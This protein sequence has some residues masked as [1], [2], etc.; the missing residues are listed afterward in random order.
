MPTVPPRAPGAQ[1]FYRLRLERKT[2]RWGGWYVP[3]TWQTDGDGAA[4]S[5]VSG[6]PRACFTTLA[7]ARACL[8]KY[9][10]A[11]PKARIV[12]VNAD[13]VRRQHARA[14][15]RLCIENAGGACAVCG[16]W[17]SSCEQC[18]GRGYHEATCPT[19]QGEGPGPYTFHYRGGP[20]VAFVGP[21][22]T[23]DEPAEADARHTLDEEARKQLEAYYTTSGFGDRRPPGPLEEERWTL[24]ELAANVCAAMDNLLADRAELYELRARLGDFGTKA[25]A[26]PPF[27][28]QGGEAATPE[29]GGASGGGAFLDVRSEE[30]AP[31][32]PAGPPQ[33]ESA[34]GG[35]P[36]AKGPPL[37]SHGRDFNLP[38]PACG[39]PALAEELAEEPLGGADLRD[40]LRRAIDAGRKPEP[41]DGPPPMC[42]TRSRVLTSIADACGRDGFGNAEAEDAAEALVRLAKMG[43]LNIHEATDA[44]RVLLARAALLGAASVKPP[45]SAAMWAAAQQRAHGAR[46]DA[47]EEARQAREALAAAMARAERAERE[48]EE[49]RRRHW[50]RIARDTN[51]INTERGRAELLALRAAQAEADRDAA[52]RH[53]EAA[54][55]HAEAYQKERD[56]AQRHAEA[57]LAEFDEL[58]HDNDAII[59]ERDAYLAN[60]T[61]TQAR[62]TELLEEVRRLK[63]RCA[64]WERA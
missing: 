24:N 62:C 33:V 13:A 41:D 54:Q 38:C 49:L 10:H 56:A 44:A 32:E 16:V 42:L 64:A 2:K 21:L 14:E 37:C 63:N 20:T 23:T 11:F 9:K 8:R 31:R 29:Q 46:I 25:A 3:Q 55:R 61:A 30:E 34:E 59:A 48:G 53:A 40:P 4:V 50:E 27:G 43:R 57:I 19:M 12:R 26:P 52:Q 51:T 47:E 5:K 28:T 35:I 60:L 15:G 18:E 6:K 58:D 36:E 7:A 39:A 17:L 22:S 45:P 1:V